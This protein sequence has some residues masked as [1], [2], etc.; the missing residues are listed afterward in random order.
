[1][2]SGKSVMTFHLTKEFFSS[3]IACSIRILAYGEMSS[4]SSH[5][6]TSPSR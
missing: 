3:A 2:Y 4:S 6:A 5:N 1:M